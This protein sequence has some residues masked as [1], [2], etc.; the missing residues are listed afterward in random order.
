MAYLCGAYAAALLLTLALAALLTPARWWRRPNVRALTVLAAGTW[1]IGSVLLALA[2]EPAAA[3]A[4]APA[5]PVLPSPP[6]QAAPPPAQYLVFEDLNLRAAPGVHAR[7]LALVPAGASVAA[8]GRRSGDWWEVRA[9]LGQRQLDGWV[10]SLW[11]RRA[12]E[13]RGQRH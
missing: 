8:T 9:T 4:H 12:E 13:A 10:S 6:V 3:A 11:L 7:R 1:G 5:T 2:P